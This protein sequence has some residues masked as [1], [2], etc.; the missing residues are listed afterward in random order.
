MSS[1]TSWQGRLAN[2]TTELAL[3]PIRLLSPVANPLLTPLTNPVRNNVQRGIRRSFGN[4]TPTIRPRNGNPFLPIDSVTRKVH[5]DLPSMVIGGVGTL[6]LQTLHP[7][8]MAGVAEHSLYREDP[9]GRFRRTAAFVEATTFGTVEDAKRAIEDVRLVH[10][11]I[12]GIS[13]DGRHYSAGDPDLLTWVHFAETWTFLR[14]AQRYGPSSLDAE[15]RDRYFAETAQIAY[16]LGAEWVP[17]SE[18]EADAY[19]SRMRPLLYAGAQALEARDFLLRGVGRRPEEKAI[20]G[21]IAAAAVG[22]LPGWARAELRIPSPP[23]VDRMVVGP[24]ARTLCVG[25]RWATL[26]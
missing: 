12:D 22:L 20:Y 11:M 25:V 17:S 1:Q 26:A 15:Q 23:L 4:E 7:L 9:I 18:Q 6:L 21:V 19:F 13:P 24:I 8:V 2:I 14:A 5:A 16:A 3:T 10:A